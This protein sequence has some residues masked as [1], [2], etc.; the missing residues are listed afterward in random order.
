MKSKSKIIKSKIF[1]ELST[2]KK[3]LRFPWWCKIIGFIL[4]QVFM[5]LSTALIIIKGIDYGDQIVQKWLTSLIISFLA[6]LL[7]T[8]PLKV[9]YLIF[10]IYIIM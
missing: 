6:S 9:K 8:Q 1:S 7:L 5:I 10:Y 2:K 4:S 3:S